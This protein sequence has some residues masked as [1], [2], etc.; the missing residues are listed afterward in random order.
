MCLVTLYTTIHAP[1]SYQYEKLMS[2]IICLPVTNIYLCV[3]TSKYRSIFLHSTFC[4]FQDAKEALVADGAILVQIINPIWVLRRL[5]DL[6]I[7][8]ATI[9][10]CDNI[11]T[12]NSLITHIGKELIFQL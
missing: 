2:C 3:I 5:F 12:D 6:A 11:S 10:Q 9:F 8:L 1:I 7:V 4:R